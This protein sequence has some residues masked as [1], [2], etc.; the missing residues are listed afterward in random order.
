MKNKFFYA[1]AAPLAVAASISF[2]SCEDEVSKIGD[3][4]FDQQVQ[5][6]VDSAV[7]KLTAPTE[8]ADK[9]DAR[10]VNN[11]LGQ[12]NVPEYGSLRASFVARL[13]SAA[14]MEIPDSIGV[15]SVDSMRM[16]LYVPRP[17]IIGDSV[18]PQ[19]LKVYELTKQLPDNIESDFSPAGYYD[20]SKPLGARNYTLS[21]LA[22]PDSAFYSLK[23]LPVSV[24]MPQSWAKNT[25]EAYRKDPSIFQWPS[26]FASKMPGIFVESSFGRGCIAPIYAVRF[27]TY[28]HHYITRTVVENEVSVK[29]RVLMKDSVCLFSTAPEVLASNNIEYTPSPSLLKR[30]ADGQKI[31]TTPTGYRVR[32]LFPGKKLLEEYLANAH[33]LSTINNLAL[34]LPAS[35]V[36]NEY[37]VGVAPTMLMIRTSEIDS[38]FAEG[39][40][41]DDKTSFVSDYNSST[42]R[43][44]FNSLRQY[45]VSLREQYGKVS[46]EEFRDLCDFTLIPV[47]LT[48]ETVSNPDGSST[49]YK[50]GCTPYMSRP[51]MTLLDMDKA[52]IV[53]TY[54]HQF[55]E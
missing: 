31:V 17:E 55:I 34:G 27:F 29:K 18:A 26:T 28:W 32:F 48:T 3:S 13:M 1:I 52:L 15:E 2:A 25:F 43:Y 16:V 51:T 14:K 12:I 10:T 6:Y 5:V 33:D 21:G 37:G 38:F 30:V 42:G 54:T 22:L 41:P 20:P 44:Y 50:T 40:I 49:V 35:K 36:A 53:F 39:K 7:Y 9:I 45:I 19:Q 46:E 11:L 8:T 23:M 24:T 47:T 4:L